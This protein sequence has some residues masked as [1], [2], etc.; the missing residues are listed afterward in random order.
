MTTAK[1][2]L[3]FA[4]L[5]YKILDQFQ[6]PVYDKIRKDDA[7]F[8]CW[9][10]EGRFPA[11][12][13]RRRFRA[14]S[15]KVPAAAGSGYYIDVGASQLII[16]GKVKLVAGQVEQITPNGRQARQTAR[17]CR[18][19]VIVY[20]HRLQLDER[21]CPPISSVGKWPKK[22]G[23]GLGA[24]LQYDQGPRPMG[25]RTAQH[26]EADAAGRPMVPR[27]QSA[28]VAPI[29]RNSFS[30]QLKKRAYEGIPTP[31]YGLQA[32]YHKGPE[33]FA[34]QGNA[35]LPSRHHGD[36]RPIFGSYKLSVSVYAGSSAWDAIEIF[37]HQARGHKLPGC[38][39]RD[40][41]ST[42]IAPGP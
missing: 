17:N 7:G 19:V 23:K 12:L 37:P 26:V 24:R 2:D 25:R 15:L 11:R 33:V 21:L 42:P 32:V 35:P 36:C 13:R 41:P 28:P 27:R 3:I 4:S 9:A 29:T 1:A 30:L 16:D 38:D 10:N 5:P 34:A 40:P 22:V 39:A 18:P 20:G 6:K 14:V 8:L 31:V